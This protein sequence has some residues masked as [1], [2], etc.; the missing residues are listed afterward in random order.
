[1]VKNF[2]VLQNHKFYGS[3]KVKDMVLSVYFY[4][5]HFKEKAFKIVWAI[6]GSRRYTVRKAIQISA[7]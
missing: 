3:N 5:G 6:Y 1:M 2:H 4:F 7:V